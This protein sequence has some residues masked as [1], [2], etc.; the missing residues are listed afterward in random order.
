MKYAPLPL[1]QSPRMPN[2]L[3]RI[4]SGAQRIEDAPQASGTLSSTPSFFSTT[5]RSS[6]FGQGRVWRGGTRSTLPVNLGRNSPVSR[7]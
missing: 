6:F 4:V 3:L 7:S 1:F 5:S 2:T